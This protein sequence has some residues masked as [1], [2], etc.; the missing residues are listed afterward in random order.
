[1]KPVGALIRSDWIVRSVDVGVARRLVERHHYAKGAPNTRTYL[2]GM[3][4]VGY[5][6]FDEQCLG[7]AWW[8]PPILN[9]AKA[10]YPTNPAGVLA[11][12]R[13][14]IAPEV[15]ANAASFL[16]SRSRKLLDRQRWPA[17]VTFADTS[18]GHTG[19]IY[20]A[21]NWT[22]EGETRPAAL[23]KFKGRQVSAKIGA[24]NRTHAE[25]LAIGCEFVGLFSK[26]KFTRICR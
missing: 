19:A 9:A 23:Y 13:L 12:S 8:L 24:I 11:L 5:D 2:H 21:D 15:P 20:R 18:Q 16:L 14:A 7:V 22:Y 10:T 4:R 3:F 6:L 17:L 26:H 1:M 25:M